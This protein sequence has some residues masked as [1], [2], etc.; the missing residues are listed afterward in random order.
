MLLLSPLVPGTRDLALRLA[1]YRAEIIVWVPGTW[2]RQYSLQ[3]LRSN[4]FYQRQLRILAA[5][6]CA[7]VPDTRGFAPYNERSNISKI[8]K[9]F[10]NK[11]LDPNLITSTSRPFTDLPYLYD[12]LC[13]SNR[14]LHLTRLVLKN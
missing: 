14:N 6:M 4:D 3:P 7:E 9:W 5:G 10:S 2:S 11:R 8:L 1:D 12:E 13:S